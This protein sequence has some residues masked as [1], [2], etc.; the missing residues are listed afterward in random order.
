M[1]YSGI[2]QWTNISIATSK[3]KDNSDWNLNS[4]DLNG[5]QKITSNKLLLILSWFKLYFTYW[6]TAID[7]HEVLIN[8]K[9]IY[10]EFE[11]VNHKRVHVLALWGAGGCYPNSSGVVVVVIVRW[12][13]LQLPMQSVP[14]TTNV[15]SSNPAQVRCTRYNII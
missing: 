13:D 5:K 1:G 6:G 8:L 7:K 2:D 15:V 14:I 3:T 10:C 4:L 11:D 12:L 9:K